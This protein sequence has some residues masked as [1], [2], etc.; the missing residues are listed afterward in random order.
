MLLWNKSNSLVN[1]SQG[2]FVSVRGDDVVVDFG[3]EGQVVVKRETWT[4]TSRTSEVV[5]SCTQF[6][7][8]LMYGITCHKSQG[9]TLPSVVLYCSKEFVPGLL[10]VSLTRVKSCHHLQVVDFNRNQLLPPVPECVDVC[11]QHTDPLEGDVTCCRKKVLD[12]EDLRVADGFEL[13][14]DDDNGFD[15]LEVTTQTENLVKSYFER[16]EPDEMVFDLQTVFMV[17]SDEASNDFWRWPPPSFNLSSILEEMK[18]A[19]PLSAFAIEKNRLIGDIIS[20]NPHKET[21]GKI[22]WGRACQIILEDS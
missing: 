3:A 2:T 9:L 6:P 12:L 21:F 22:L 8:A 7:L 4:N 14:N 20:G 19:D 15:V 10:Y 11:A 1:G 5:G 17:L 13:P 16:G 18:V